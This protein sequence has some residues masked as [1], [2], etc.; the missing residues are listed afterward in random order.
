MIRKAYIYSVILIV[1]VFELQVEYGKR[2]AYYCAYQA[3]ELV[4]G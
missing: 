3:I 4:E 2:F 1:P